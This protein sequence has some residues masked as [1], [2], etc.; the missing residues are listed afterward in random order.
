AEVPALDRP[1]VVE[2][3]FHNSLKDGAVEPGASIRVDNLA[4]CKRLPREEED[5]KEVSLGWTG[6]GKYLLPLRASGDGK[7]YQVVVIPPSPGYP[8]RGSKLNGSPRIYPVKGDLL[9]QYHEIRGA[10]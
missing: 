7:S 1:V 2:Q 5:A 10:R 3:V 8:P 4:D 6:P 9:E